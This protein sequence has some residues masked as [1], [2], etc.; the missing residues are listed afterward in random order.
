MNSVGVPRTSPDARPLSTSPSDPPHDIRAGPV[1][2]EPCDVEPELGRVAL[3]VGAFQRLLAMEE[4]LM[5]LPEP[6]LQGS[7]LDCGSRRERVRVNLGEREVAEREADAAARP[8]L[9]ARISR[10]ARRE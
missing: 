1:L 10:N 4:Q 5:H 8:L 3:K 9:D 2:V 6:V 7:R